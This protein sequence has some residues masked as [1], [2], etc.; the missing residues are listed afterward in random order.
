M[1]VSKAAF[2]VMGLEWAEQS[3]HLPALYSEPGSMWREDHMQVGL[4]WC[5]GMFASNIN[6]S[7]TSARADWYRLSAPMNA[8]VMAGRS[9]GRGNCLLTRLCHGF[10]LLFLVLCW[11]G[12][13]SASSKPPCWLSSSSTS[14]NPATALG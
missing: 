4:T 10:T 11:L 5:K 8:T 2:I 7:S 13:S 3:C 14:P 12:S 9:R 6:M 1:W